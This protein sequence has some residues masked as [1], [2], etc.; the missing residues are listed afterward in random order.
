[1]QQRLSP[2]LA[3]P[4]TIVYLEVYPGYGEAT[5][6][7]LTM[8]RQRVLPR[9]ESYWLPILLPPALPSHV[10]HHAGQGGVVPG[11]NQEGGGL[12]AEHLL[13]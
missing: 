4:L 13:A 8:G 2:Y 9:E 6:T 10:L 12:L 11:D 5:V 7:P 1:M 3:L